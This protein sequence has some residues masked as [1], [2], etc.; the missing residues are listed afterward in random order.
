MNKGLDLETE[1]QI[2]WKVNQY[3]QVQMWSFTN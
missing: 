3:Q 1:N 2:I